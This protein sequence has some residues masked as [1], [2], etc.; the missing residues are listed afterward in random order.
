MALNPSSRMDPQTAA[1]RAVSVIGLGYDLTSDI[2]LTAC[3]IGPNGSGLIEVD[4]KSTKDLLVPGGVV[5]SNV[6][7]SIKCD[8]GERTR[9]RSDA[10]SFSQMSEQLNQ[11][12][13][14]SGKIPS[15]LFNAMFGHKGC[16]QKDAAST[17]LLAF[18]GWFITLYNIE[19]V[20]S[21]LTL[22]EQVKQDVPSSWDPPALAE[23]IEKYGTHIVVG[24]KMGGKDVIHIKQLQNSILQ[25]ME[26]QKLLKQ[27]ADEKF[28]EDVNGC[29]IA[30]SVR[31]TEKSKGEK[32]IFSD[33]H[34]PFANSM[35]PSIMSHS[36]ADD[37][38]SIH[39]RRG[40]LDFGQ[41]HSQW[42]PTVSQ[43]PNAISM[44]FVPIASLLSGVRG[45][46][47]LSHA[48]NLYLR[49]KPPIEE[50]EQFLEF[51]LPR[52]WAPAYGDLPLGHRRRKQA[53]PSL[54][55][56][57]MGPR[58]YVNTVKVDS[59][60]R[61]VT[62]IRLYL[63]GKRSDHLAIH[64]QHLS[65]L[66]QSIQL[67]DDLSYEPVDEPVER[68]YLEP[69]KWSIFS[70]VCTAPVEYR[71]TRIDDSA[72][73]VTKAW[74][75]VKVIGM[76][77]VLFLRLGFS[78]VASAKIR[79]SEWEGPATTCRKSGLISMLITTPF[80]TKLNQ[81]QKPTKVDLN[82]AV[83]PGGPPSPA[84]APKMS[85]FVDTT[86]MVR[87]PEESPGYWVVTGVKL[88]VEDSRIRMKVKYSLLTILTEES[89]LI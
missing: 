87:G 21:H 51:Q 58:L 4:Q 20:R 44:S 47:F 15:G 22:S 71:G 33:P 37:L 18:D 28:S 75:E 2:R 24:V 19:L 17:K 35:R 79:R 7:T 16:W 74:F 48:I 12:L 38:L 84:R 29:Q 3:K 40:G 56:T 9:F 77:K 73:I 31:S 65:A 45:S 39:I 70:H 85:H 14:L 5:V 50:L 63:E 30:K 11:E 8:K 78:M 52:Q 81:P 43:S 13:S 36:K 69:V 57:L 80:S 34:L 64:L 6:S 55:F 59:G 61:P 82:S 27:L 53:S 41:S 86:E 54:Q 88:C 26:V 60:N 83:Y 62:G 67:T 10:L 49:Y 89:L 66:P 76:K 72:S 68:G 23:F 42:L 32:S 46:G 1:E 25:P